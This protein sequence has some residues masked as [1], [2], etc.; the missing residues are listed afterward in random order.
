[1]SRWLL[2][3]LVAGFAGLALIMLALPSKDYGNCLQSEKYT[4]TQ[5]V[6]VGNI[7]VGQVSIPQFIYLP[8]EG[9]RCTRWEYPEGR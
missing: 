6:W 5:S 1:M 8:T 4:Y 7:T 2:L 9:L 3:I